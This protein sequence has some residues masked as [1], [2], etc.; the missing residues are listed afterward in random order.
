MVEQAVFSR[1][2]SELYSAA[3]APEQWA[4]AMRGIGHAF[5]CEGAAF[6]LADG[7]ARMIT[8]SDIAADAAVSYADHYC[9]L[10]FVLAEV[11]TG[12]VG[13][14]RTGSELIWPR[15][16]CEFVT[17]WALRHDFGDGMFVRL[18][19]RI[20]LA[21]AA[22]RRSTPFDTPERLELLTLLVPHLQQA[23]RMQRHVEELA[24]RNT[25]LFGACNVYGHGAIVVSGAG[26]ILHANPVAERILRAGDALRAHWQRLEAA[27]TSVGDRLEAALRG[28]GA[29]RSGRSFLCPRPAGADPY[30]IHVLPIEHC[31]RSLIVI[32][33]TGVHHEPSPTLLRRLYRLTPS[34]AQVALRVARGTGLIRIA[35][36]LSVSPAT[37]KTHL[38]HVFDKTGTHRQA[39]LVRLLLNLGPFA[40][41]AAR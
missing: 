24:S 25:D 14:V 1:L 31:D 2:V 21:V 12:P 23:L 35:D 39:E 19:D 6:V 41:E 27:T 38:R 18:D 20:S 17:D 32:V 13:A 16:N 7:D 33:D 37:V 40:D 30:V 36:E 26:R 3:T 9:R 15:R 22:A 34:E 11:Q 4:T 8:H 29:D 5:G 28:N 10:D